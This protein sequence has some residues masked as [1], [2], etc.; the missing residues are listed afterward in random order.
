MGELGLGRPVYQ[1]FGKMLVFR[2]LFEGY[3]GFA[4]KTVDSEGGGEYKSRC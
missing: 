1:R 3:C 2:W 4:A